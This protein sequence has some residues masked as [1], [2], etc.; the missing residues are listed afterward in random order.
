MSAHLLFCHA[1]ALVRRL[2]A[3]TRTRFA[4]PQVRS[5]SSS[6]LPGRF[7]VS[8]AVDRLKDAVCEEWCAFDG[9]VLR[10]VTFKISGF[11]SI[12]SWSLL[13]TIAA[14]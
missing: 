1:C 4:A 12:I 2:P 7:S 13:R 9:F 8:V 3:G 14:S 11:E 10:F 6:R 5:G